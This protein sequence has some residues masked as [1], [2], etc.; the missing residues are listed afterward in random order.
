MWIKANEVQL[1]RTLTTRK[2]IQYRTYRVQTWSPQMQKLELLALIE[3]LR[4][5]LRENQKMI[6]YS[7]W[8]KNSALTESLECKA[9]L[10]RRGQAEHLSAVRHPASIQH[11][12]GYERVWAEGRRAAYPM[13]DPHERAQI[14]TKV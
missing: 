8:V 7:P 6:V 4:A 5:Q 14:A 1:F 2:N 12:R 3:D 9:C 10:R 11:H 13:R